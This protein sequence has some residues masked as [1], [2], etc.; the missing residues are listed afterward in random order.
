MAKAIVPQQPVIASTSP[1]TRAVPPALEPPAFPADFLES[2]VENGN[3]MLHC[4]LR[5]AKAPPPVIDLANAVGMLDAYAQSIAHSPSGQ[6]EHHIN[7]SIH[8]FASAL[9]CAMAAM[10]DLNGVFLS[11]YSHTAPR[12]RRKRPA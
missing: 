8:V 11:G 5:D 2:L 4:W 6:V 12:S 9:V 3:E 7:E 1:V 10:R